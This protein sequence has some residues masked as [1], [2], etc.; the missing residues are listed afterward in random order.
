MTKLLF[1][2]DA[3]QQSCTARVISVQDRGVELD[4]T[5]F[6]A[7]SGGQAGDCGVLRCGDGREIPVT[8]TIKDRESGRYLHMIA[9]GHDLP[10]T[11]SS[12]EA[13]LDWETRYRHMRF[14][15]CLHLLCAVIDGSV[16][17]GNIASHKSR[18]DFDIPDTVPDKD[19]LTDQIN[20]LI[21]RNARVFDGEI[22]EAELRANPEL[23]RTMSVSP[24]MDGGVIRTI[25]IEGIDYQ[26]CG[27]THVRQTLEIG[28]II[29]AKIEKKGRQNR[30]INIVFD[31]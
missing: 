11:G 8:T 24:P 27:G 20:A 13:A 19:E 23:V 15:T 3:Y 14:H 1:R 29:V 10:D 12:I 25:T 4:Q 17:G 9:D 22:S 28:K 7:T 5:V 18:L 2:E 16:T 31:E 6:Y 26:P 30:R 21:A